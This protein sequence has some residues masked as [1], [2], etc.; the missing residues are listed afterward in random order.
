MDRDQAAVETYRYLRVGLVGL[1]VLLMVAV[2]FQA[3]S[4]GELL[5]SISAYYFTGVR[6][7]FVGVL[8]ALGLGLIVV[9]GRGVEDV[10]LNLAGMLAPV[11]AFV[12]TSTSEAPGGAA[13]YGALADLDSSPLP[14]QAGGTSTVW[15]L[16]VVGTLGLG[17]AAFTAR[18]L[19]GRARSDALR[20]VIAGGVV[21]AGLAAWLAIGPDSFLR[22]AHYVAAAG[23]FGVFVVVSRLNARS[24][25]DTEAPVMRML[26]A[27]RRRAAYAAISWSMLVTVVVAGVLGLLELGGRTPVDHWLFFVEAILLALFATF[28]VLQTIEY[29]RDGVPLGPERGQSPPGP[30]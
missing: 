16:V 6:D 14:A 7:V 29:W 22:V 3:I 4:D 10:L 18:R 12:P 25:V 9:R 30:E 2:A 28:W 23:L 5:G 20:G 26:P 21:V 11:V 1:A 27:E 24:A 19:S 17:F 15:S 13:R 8:V